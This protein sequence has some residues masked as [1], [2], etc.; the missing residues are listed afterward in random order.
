MIRKTKLLI[1]LTA[2]FITSCGGKTAEKFRLSPEFYT[3]ENSGINYVPSSNFAE[4]Y[5]V[6]VTAKIK[7][8]ASFGVYVYSS[9]CGTCATFSPILDNYLKANNL[10]LYGVQFS[11]LKPVK[12]DLYK[13]VTTVPYLAMYQEGRVRAYLDSWES[14][15][16]EYFS[17][18]SKFALWF[19]TNIDISPN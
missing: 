8:K 14:S 19:S 7:A 9:T 3:S 16:R 13:R 4:E 11:D 1:V 10:K 6:T 2:L 17:S 12:D 5:A 18:A 15:D